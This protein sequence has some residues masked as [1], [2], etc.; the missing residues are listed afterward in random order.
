[1]PD[2]LHEVTIAASPDKVYKAITEQ[3]AR[4]DHRALPKPNG[5]VG[6]FSFPEPVRHKNGDRRSLVG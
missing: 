5:T 1:M 6:E 2:I 3:Q 4:G